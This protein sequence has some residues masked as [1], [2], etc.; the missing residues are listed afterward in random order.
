MKNVYTVRQVNTYIKNM[1]TQDFMLNRIYVKGE[2]SNC[3]YHT[4]GHIYFSL[5][6]ESGTIACVMFA[7]HRSGL[8]FR[9]QEGQQVI[10]LG[11]V[12]VYERSGQY[13]LYAREI[14]LDGAGA[15]YEKFEALKKELAEMGMFAREYKQPIP[16]YIH[17]LG[18]VTAPTGAAVRDIINIAGRRNPYVQIILYPAQVQGEGAAESIVRG[19]RAL[20][21]K[22]VDVMIVGR[23]GGSIEDLWAFNE[24]PV[25]RAIFECS[26]PVISAVGHETDTTIADFVADLRAPTPSA[27]AEL[28]VYDHRE[29]RERIRTYQEAM[30]RQVTL[31]ISEKRSALERLRMRLN[32]AHP[33]QK[34]NESRQYA[35][36]LETRL[37]LLMQNRLDREK[38]RL[39]LCVEKMK[40]LSPLEKLSHGYS[41]IQNQNGENIRSIRQVSD[42]TALEIYVSDGRIHALVTGSGEEIK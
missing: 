32:Y 31:K 20:E 24:E 5:K 2:V 22:K 9:L 15:L 27:A 26:I 4:S 36:D 40:G 12:S 33:R 25:A 7:G 11:S 29:A 1:F 10:V 6:D 19:I 34:L 21:K 28:A 37:R 38:H 13:Q 8:S 3:K 42:G 35:A 16:K 30:L 23:G 17:T 39:A 18:V 41:Y 14:M